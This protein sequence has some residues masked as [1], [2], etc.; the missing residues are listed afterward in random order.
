MLLDIY[1]PYLSKKK[2][3]VILLFEQSILLHEY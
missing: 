1:F 3:F 2:I